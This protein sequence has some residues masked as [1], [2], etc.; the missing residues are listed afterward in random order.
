MEALIWIQINKQRR[1]RLSPKFLSKYF[2]TLFCWMNFSQ[3]SSTFLARSAN[4]RAAAKSLSEYF[5]INLVFKRP[6]VP[7]RFFI[8]K[9]WRKFSSRI[10]H[11]TIKLLHRQSCIIST[12]AAIQ[13]QSKMVTYRHW[14]R[15]KRGRCSSIYFSYALA[16]SAINFQ[17]GQASWHISGVRKSFLQSQSLDTK[18]MRGI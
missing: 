4:S 11:F 17:Q 1:L 12:A 3:F 13:F 8:G 7:T 5:F 15:W 14:K 16:I 9:V 6:S 2:M 18:T 10:F